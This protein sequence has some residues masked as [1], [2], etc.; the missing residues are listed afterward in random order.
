MPAYTCWTFAGQNVV[1]SIIAVTAVINLPASGG[2]KEFV[3]DCGEY[4]SLPTVHKGNTPGRGGFPA[5][6]WVG[7]G[8]LR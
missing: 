5:G 4:W 6:G 8:A 3:Y 2:R 7:S 1:H